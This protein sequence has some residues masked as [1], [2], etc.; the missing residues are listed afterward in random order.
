MLDQ[1]QALLKKNYNISNISSETN[2]K[3]DLGLTSFDFI[4][5]IALIEDT[6]GVELEEEKYQSIHTAGE[7]IAYIEE[8]K[9]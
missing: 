5:L 8:V 9:H 7:L 4:N 6:F 3:T 2:I 1:L